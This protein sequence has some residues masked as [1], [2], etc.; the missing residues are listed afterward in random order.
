MTQQPDTFDELIHS[1]V[2]L[3]I[4]AALAT[5]TALEFTAIE[6]ALRIST[7]TLSK[8]LGVLG[9]A[10]YVTLDKRKQPFGR[11]RT[12][13]SLTRKGRRAFDAHV[14]ALRRL[15]GDDVTP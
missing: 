3:K 6:D 14:A 13:V 8:Q 2:R 11:P 4:C 10:G 9:E 1:P 7:S 12:W 15:I 5:A